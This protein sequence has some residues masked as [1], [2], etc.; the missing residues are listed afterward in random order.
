MI[1]NTVCYLTVTD[2]YDV[3]INAAAWFEHEFAY[4]A[5]FATSK[6]HI[7]LDGGAYVYILNS[8][9]R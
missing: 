2:I 3:N 1:I 8:N 7:M 9:A 5:C 6:T 4:C